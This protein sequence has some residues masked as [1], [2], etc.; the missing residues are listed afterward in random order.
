MK[1]T[2]KEWQEK[3]GITILDPD[4]WRKDGKSFDEPIDLNEWNERM[5][6]STVSGFKIVR[7]T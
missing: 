7:S 3:T 1:L 2:P 5:F 6:I 4:G